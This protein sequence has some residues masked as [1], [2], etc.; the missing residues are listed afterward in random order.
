[1]KQNTSFEWWPHKE[2]TPIFAEYYFLYLWCQ[3][4]TLP[5]GEDIKIWETDFGDEVDG[6]ERLVAPKPCY[7]YCQCV[8][9]VPS[10]CI[11][12]VRSDKIDY[13][14]CYCVYN[15]RD[16]LSFF[17]HPLSSCYSPSSKKAVG[18]SSTRRGG[19][20]RWLMVPIIG[21]GGG[22]GAR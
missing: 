19:V 2:K 16:T 4:A 3:R 22:A 8:T 20:D 21:E 12:S 10:L 9:P 1:M 13:T 6:D 7:Y 11:Q 15:Q 14:S 18:P 17:L 5:A